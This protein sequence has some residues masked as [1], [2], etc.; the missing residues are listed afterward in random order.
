MA[1]E[2]DIFQKPEFECLS[3]FAMGYGFWET[4]QP[5]ARRWWPSAEHY[6]QAGKFLDPGLQE[7][8]RLAEEPGIAKHLGRTLSPLRDDWDD[9]KR[10]RIREAM[11]E[12]LW[13]HRGV[14]EV[15]LG[16]P[17][18]ARIVNGNPADPYFGTGRDGGGSNVIGEVLMELHSFLTSNPERR[19]LGLK[20]GDVGPPL[21]PFCA[22]VDLTGVSPGRVCAELAKALGVA[23]GVFDSVSLLVYDYERKP[24]DD[25]ESA[26]QLE[27]FLKQNGV[28]EVEA[29]LK[30]PAVAT[31]W[32]GVD[33]SFLARVDLRYLCKDVDAVVQ[34][35]TD[36]MPLMRHPAFSPSVTFSIDGSEPQKLD[37][38]AL[39]EVIAAAQQMADVLISGHYEVPEEEQAPL[40]APPEA[41]DTCVPVICGRHTDL[42]KSTLVNR[43]KG[44][45]WGA[46]L[47]DAVGLATEFMK[48]SQASEAYPDPS[49]LSPATRK[50]DTHRS[51]W[52]QGDWT[53]DTDQFVLL[54]DAIV[55]GGGILDQKRFAKSLKSWRREGFPELG[56]R[57]GLG[58]GQ[59]VNGVL[60]SP[61]YDV[62]PDIAADAEWRQSA[63]TAAAN[64][65]VM[66]CAAAALGCF[67]DEAVVTYNAAAGAAVTH[68]DPRCIASSVMVALIASRALT[69]VDLSSPARRREEVLSALQAAR[70]CL[71]GGDADELER[72]SD[73]AARGLEGLCLGSGGIGYTYK[74]LAAACWAFLH[75]GS[76]KD[77]IQA[78]TMEAGD[79]DS[80]AT[81]AGALL[82]ARLG[83][84]CLPQEWLGEVPELQRRWLEQ[85]IAAYV[86][87]LGL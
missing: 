5:L 34:R 9:V 64:G 29:C 86:Q 48:K 36:L 61:A 4:S 62:A 18:G 49:K 77:A 33:D 45:I 55:A 52:V 30:E 46:A 84:S 87:M 12:K 17:E 50:E 66:R 60:E 24:I 3:N 20:V 1:V 74:P 47:G 13:A 63:C 67:W 22:W 11:L 69:V 83:F 73:V 79:A 8:V 23:P 10:C 70:H 85:K 42:D 7:Q 2:V 76:F 27:A 28:C 81:V 21:D 35:L 39:S 19:R 57:A 40:R 25:F 43:I 15:L 44:L 31:L 71:D 80:N 56:D 72:H 16:I 54:L 68:A 65:A 38:A 75:A 53:D 78:I 82:G 37:A 6:F 41:G 59:T 58:I 14:R 26:A 32:N 51:R